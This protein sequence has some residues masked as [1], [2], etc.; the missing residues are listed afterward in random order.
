MSNEDYE[1]AF[2]T[3]GVETDAGKDD[4][5]G[6]FVTRYIFKIKKSAIGAFFLLFEYLLLMIN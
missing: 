1:L 4:G 2:V 3:S 5:N 6:I